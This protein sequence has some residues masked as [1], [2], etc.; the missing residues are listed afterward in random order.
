MA[1]IL[2]H[3]RDISNP[4]SDYQRKTVMRVLQEI[5][6]EEETITEKYVEVWN[7][8]DLADVEMRTKLYNMETDFPA[9]IMNAVGGEGKQNFLAEVDKLSSALK[10]K[11][12]IEISYPYYEHDLRTRWLFDK[13]NVTN[14]EEFT[15]SDDGSIIT[16]KL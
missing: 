6:I 1:D 12:F 5:G 13:A 4:Q 9:V 16:V 2:V 14:Y 3:V 15:V 11:Q 10:G 8:I 7:K